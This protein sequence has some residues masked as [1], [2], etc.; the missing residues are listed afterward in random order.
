MPRRYHDAADLIAD[1]EVDLVTIT[2]PPSAHEALVV[3][4]LDAGKYVFCEKP[5][6][7]SLASAVRI[8]VAEA[9]HPGRLAVSY[10]LRYDPSFRRLIWLCSNGWIGKIQS[11]LI[12][13]H[14]YIP[15][16]NHGKKG[17]WGSWEIAGGGVFMTQL[18][19]ELDLLLLA[20]G[21][22]LSVSAAMDTRYTGIESEDYA[23]ATFRFAGETT[24]RCVASVN[25]GRLGGGFTIQG[26]SGAVGLPWSFTLKDQSRMPKAMKALDRALPYT[27]PQSSSL[28]GRGTRF[29]ARRFGV[30]SKVVLTPHALL[31]QEIVRQH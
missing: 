18:I 27:R 25:S 10:Q 2:T 15:H 16:S 19:H 22:P 12:E 23:E 11:A 20:M 28:V 8:A 21:R 6:A 31:Y 26:S 17:W 30:K 24:A 3:A 4:A 1:P 9:R 14:S 13:R 29:L 7:H 5:L